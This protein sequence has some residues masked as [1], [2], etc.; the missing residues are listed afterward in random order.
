MIALLMVWR[1]LWRETWLNGDD[2]DDLVVS[3]NSLFT[4]SH[5]ALRQNITSLLKRNRSRNERDVIFE[6]AFSREP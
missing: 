4:D 5:C 3:F 2:D 1:S 6:S